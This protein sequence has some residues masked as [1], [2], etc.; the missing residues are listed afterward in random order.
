MKPD[1]YHAVVSGSR[2]G[3]EARA[4]LFEELRRYQEFLRAGSAPDD[5]LQL[6]GEVTADSYA[7]PKT[8]PL[9]DSLVVDFLGSTAATALAERAVTQQMSGVARSW[10][11]GRLER[12]AGGAA[13][14]WT[15]V[16]AAQ[17]EDKS[18]LARRNAIEQI[19]RQGRLSSAGLLLREAA[20]S[21]ACTRVSARQ[22][23]LDLVANGDPD[24]SSN[25]SV[26]PMVVAAR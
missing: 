8:R 3:L 24:V 12:V 1:D 17:L 15:A 19:H 16:Y 25:P 4:W 26:L 22:A 9:A 2:I 21:D 18:C 10:I 11:I 6:I 20:K 13:L 14:D 7:Y 5:H 23:A